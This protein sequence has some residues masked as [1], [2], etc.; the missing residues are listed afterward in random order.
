[1]NYPYDYVLAMIGLYLKDITRLKSIGSQQ[2][3]YEQ[4]IKLTQNI[5]GIDFL[6][7]PFMPKIEEKAN[8]YIKY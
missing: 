7:V 5:N 3:R 2:R 1:M 4:F 8:L 6:F